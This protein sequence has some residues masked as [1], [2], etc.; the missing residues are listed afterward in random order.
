M[1]KS[2]PACSNSWITINLGINPKKGGRP[3]NDNN[4][5]KLRNWIVRGIGKL[6]NWFKWLQ[7]ILLKRCINGA[8]KTI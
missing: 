3:P 5:K 2:V 6:D 7:L 1:F 4:K 8:N